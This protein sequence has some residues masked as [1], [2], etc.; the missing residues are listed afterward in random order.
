MK[1]KILN[2]FYYFALAALLLVTAWMCW[3]EGIWRELTNMA[4]VEYHHAVG[5]PIDLPDLTD[6]YK[7]SGTLR[8]TG[9]WTATTTTQEKE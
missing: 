9:L 2:I 5:E 4:T 3:R 1:P 8:V 6:A 7:T